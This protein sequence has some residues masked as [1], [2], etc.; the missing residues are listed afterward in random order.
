[1]L[2]LRSHR[3]QTVGHF[4][5]PIPSATASISINSDRKTIGSLRVFEEKW[6]G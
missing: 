4:L 1:L 3:E 5:F 2:S 6:C